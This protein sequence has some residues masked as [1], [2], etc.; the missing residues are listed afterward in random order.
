MERI[1]R[2]TAS[3]VSAGHPWPPDWDPE[4]PWTA[5][6]RLAAEDTTFWDEQV[7]QPAA[8]SVASGSRGHPSTPEEDMARVRLPGGLGALESPLEGGF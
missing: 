2:R 1:R 3:S 7:R 5:V 8:A 6:F 4:R